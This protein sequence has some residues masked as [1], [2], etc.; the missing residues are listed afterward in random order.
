M[1]CAEG[2]Q[3]DGEAQ[4]AQGC[5]LVEATSLGDIVFRGQQANHEQPQD[6]GGHREGGARKFKKC[7]EK[8][9]LHGPTDR[10]SASNSTTELV[11]GHTFRASGGAIRGSNIARANTLQTTRRFWRYCRP[12]G[13]YVS[14]CVFTFD[15]R[16]HLILCLPEKR[17]RAI[18]LV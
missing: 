14:L 15:V 8:S 13:S 10:Y 4:V 12:T 6:G 17:T 3:R 5:D 1:F 9:W 18:S 11:Q 16:G 7:G 2:R